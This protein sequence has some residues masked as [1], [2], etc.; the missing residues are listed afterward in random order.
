MKQK[1]QKKEIKFVVQ[2]HIRVHKY[3][4][5]GFMFFVQNIK[6]YLLDWR[7]GPGSK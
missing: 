7:L 6:P 3:K 2:I 4:R 5:K 1:Q